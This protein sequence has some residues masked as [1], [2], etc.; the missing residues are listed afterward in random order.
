MSIKTYY[1]N[2]PPAHNNPVVLVFPRD[3]GSISTETVRYEN[4]QWILC[5]N[6]AVLGYAIYPEC[7]WFEIPQPPEEDIY[8]FVERVGKRVSERWGIANNPGEYS[9]SADKARQYRDQ[10][11]DAG[12]PFLY[13]V[14]IYV[15]STTHPYHSQI[16]DRSKV[17]EWV[18]TYWN[19]NPVFQR[20]LREEDTG[21]AYFTIYWL[22]GERQVL[23]ARPGVPIHEAFTYAGYGASATKA[24]DFYKEGVC[25]DYSWDK[26][27]NKWVR[28]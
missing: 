2:N 27:T 1:A 18:I 14:F 7:Y 11:E 22:H 4:D 23:H 19:E 26:E 5:N 8:K 9:L 12:V 25:D 13:G 16:T 17:A 6:S 20:I 24:I 10:W 21:K 3:N 28:K 15:M